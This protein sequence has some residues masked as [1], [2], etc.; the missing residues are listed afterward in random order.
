MNTAAKPENVAWMASF[1]TEW[2]LGGVLAG[3]AAQAILE[4]TGEAG[5]DARRAANQLPT[6][7]DLMQELEDLED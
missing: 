2:A 5:I 4:L 6:P 7:A 3:D 1:I